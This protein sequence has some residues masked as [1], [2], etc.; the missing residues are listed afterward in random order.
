MT[1]IALNSR[2]TLTKE[3]STL[4]TKRID[5]TNGKNH[6]AINTKFYLRIS[7]GYSSGRGVLFE[8]L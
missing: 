4:V 7:V 2:V 8:P 3:N 5:R 1:K 6:I